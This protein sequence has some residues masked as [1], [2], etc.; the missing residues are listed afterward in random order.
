ML[1]F[2]RFGVFADYFIYDPFYPIVIFFRNELN[3]RFGMKV[4]IVPDVV[5]SCFERGVQCAY[6]D[7]FAEFAEFGHSAIKVRIVSH[8]RFPSFRVVHTKTA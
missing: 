3:V 8:V 1:G 7:P 6:N 4:R 5:F 2:V